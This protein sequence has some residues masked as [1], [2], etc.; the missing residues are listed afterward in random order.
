MSVHTLSISFNFE[1][2]ADGSLPYSQKPTHVQSGSVVKLLPHGANFDQGKRG[3]ED[4]F[5]SQSILRCTD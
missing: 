1:V 5:S 2:T 4:K 3:S